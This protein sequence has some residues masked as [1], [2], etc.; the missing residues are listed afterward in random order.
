MVFQALR[1]E[2]PQ[3]GKWRTGKTMCS[4]SRG[5]INNLWNWSWHSL[6]GGH[7]LTSFLGYGVWTETIPRGGGLEW[8]V[9][10]PPPQ[11]AK[12]LGKGTSFWSK[13][14]SIKMKYQLLTSMLHI[15]RYPP[16]SKK[17]YNNLNH[18][19]TLKIGIGRLQYPTLRNGHVIQTKSKTVNTKSRGHCKL[20]RPNRYS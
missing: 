14:N 6:G 16:L 4:F 8:K 19:L 3:R 10:R 17:H 15:Q 12:V 7:H 20:N 2:R 1:Q 9:Q 18:I 13:D 11:K 5:Q